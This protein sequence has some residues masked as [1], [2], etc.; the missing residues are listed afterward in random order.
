[1]RGLIALALV[2]LLI[3]EYNTSDSE[4]IKCFRP[5][6]AD[7]LR[8]LPGRHHLPHLP[9]HVHQGIYVQKHL[10]IKDGEDYW[11]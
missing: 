6:A 5:S 1:M 8:C 3:N 2:R 11:F 7:Y 4:K 9:L 10:Y